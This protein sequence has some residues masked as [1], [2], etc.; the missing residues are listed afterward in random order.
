[1]Q[2]SPDEFK[3]IIKQNDWNHVHLIARGNTII[4]IF[5]G[6]VTSV[7]VDDDTKGDV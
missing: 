5:N 7:V 4:Q 2:Q 6:T 3:A 1:M